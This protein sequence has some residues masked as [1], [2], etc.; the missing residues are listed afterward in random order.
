MTSFMEFTLMSRVNRA[1]MVKGTICLWGISHTSSNVI[2]KI[3]TRT[4]LLHNGIL[5]IDSSAQGLPAKPPSVA[6]T[7]GTFSLAC[8]IQWCL[9]HNTSNKQPL[10]SIL[11]F[12]ILIPPK[13]F[14]FKSFRCTLLFY[15]NS[16]SA[17]KDML[18]RTFQHFAPFNSHGSQKYA[19]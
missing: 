9:L 3:D 15:I 13:M 6:H 11:H 18:Q 8:G 2:T 4:G 16:F 5:V 1:S 14:P 7:H 17:K 12:S 19:V 10:Y